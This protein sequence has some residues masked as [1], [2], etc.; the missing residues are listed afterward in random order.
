MSTENFIQHLHNIHSSQQ[1][2][3]EG[4]GQGEEKG[5]GRA[6]KERGEEEREERR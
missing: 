1:L 3:E 5:G 2:M 6:R 4:K